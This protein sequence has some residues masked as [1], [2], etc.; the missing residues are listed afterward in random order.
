MDRSKTVELMP[1]MWRLGTGR[2]YPS[3]SKAEDLRSMR[4]M[5]A[6]IIPLLT[7]WTEHE[8]CVIRTGAAVALRHIAPGTSP[9]HDGLEMPCDGSGGM[10]DKPQHLV[11]FLARYRQKLEKAIHAS[12]VLAPAA[13]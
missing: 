10:D 5:G 9:A 12:A 3:Y 6:G 2:T 1:I 8:C 4:A 13:P 7:D 11:T